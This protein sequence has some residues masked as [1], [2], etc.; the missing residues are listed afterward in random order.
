MADADWWATFFDGAAREAWRLA[1]PREVNRA[2]ARSIV[3]CLGL[4]PGDEV[5][6]VPCGEGRLALELASFG[7]RVWGL[8]ACAES[9]AAAR[10]AAERA[11]L[12]IEFVRGD[13]RRLSWRERF[14]AAFCVGNSFGLFDEAGDRAFL[15]GVANSLR[16][17]GRF[18]LEYPLVAELV[19][20]QRLG[21]DWRFLGEHLLLS[22]SALDERSGRLEALHTFVDLA[23]PSVREERTASYRVYA[24]RELEE[25]VR[26]SGFAVE[27]CF[28]GW[29]GRPFGTGAE[30]C[31]LVAARR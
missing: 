1:H 10:A 2:E 3:R 4:E 20:T 26:A 24:V 14:A 25:L 23:R 21:R 15:E 17:G 9:L 18:L 29:D 28:G 19:A 22:E 30:E 11:G 12:E 31:L 5:L 16:R 13:M 7:H 27:A 6:D 8:D